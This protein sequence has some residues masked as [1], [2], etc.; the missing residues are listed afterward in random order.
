VAGGTDKLEYP[1]EVVHYLFVF[2]AQKA[3]ASLSH[4]AVARC[5]VICLF[6]VYDPIH[7]HDQ[8]GGVAVE[9]GDESVNELLAAKVVAVQLVTPQRVP[10]PPFGRGHFAT[11]FSGPPDFGRDDFLAGDD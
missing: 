1:W 8:T 2:Y 7:F 9:I 11:Q 4:D 5:I 3:Q 6:V 10:E